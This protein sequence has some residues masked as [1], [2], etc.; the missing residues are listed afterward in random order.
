GEAVVAPFLRNQ[1]IDHIDTLIVSHGDNDHLGGVAGLL[2]HIPAKQVL[3]SAPERLS[4][5]QPKRCIRGQPWRWDR[6]DFEILYP[7]SATGHGN[8]YSC[9]LRITSGKQHVLIAGDI[10][11]SAEQKL[12]AI[13]AHKLSATILVA[14]HHGSLSSSS[15]A[16]IAAVHPK[17]VLFAVGYRNR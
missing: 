6:V 13:N 14:P 9:V 1:S 4:W 10:E 3:T 5:T 15:P 17:N 12:V 7:R 8:N 11:R 2:R 16:F